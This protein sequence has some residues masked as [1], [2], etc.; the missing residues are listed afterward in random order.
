MIYLVSLIVDYVL[1]VLGPS[2]QNPPS[3]ACRTHMILLPPPD[4]VDLVPNEVEGLP[5]H[6]VSEATPVS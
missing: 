3:V 1:L 5:T 6:T 2:S 4:P